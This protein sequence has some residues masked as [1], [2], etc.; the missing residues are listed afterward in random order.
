MTY[1]QILIEFLQKKHDILQKYSKE[2][3]LLPKDVE[4]VSKWSA[5]KIKEVLLGL[6]LETD[7]GNCPWCLYHNFNQYLGGACCKC[8]YAINHGRCSGPKNTYVRIKKDLPDSFLKHYRTVSVATIT[9]N[10][11]IQ[12]LTIYTYKKACIKAKINTGE[13]VS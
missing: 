1:K 2:P 3:F 6:N 4:D 8:E 13:N 7:S 12:Q 10:E 9:K 11:E 5:L